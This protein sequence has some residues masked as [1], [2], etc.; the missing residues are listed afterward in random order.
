M[1][2]TVRADGNVST[3]SLALRGDYFRLGPNLPGSVDY[4]V[5][6]DGS[7][8]MLKD[9]GPTIA[10]RIEVVVNWQSA[11]SPREKK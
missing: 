8:L 9:E 3:P 2:V 7:F 10:P 4:D 6:P 1:R 11:R 5:F